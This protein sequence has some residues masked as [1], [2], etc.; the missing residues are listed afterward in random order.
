METVTATPPGANPPITET[1]S[2][3][4]AAAESGDLSTFL[5]SEEDARLGKP[6]EK[7]TR[8]KP[9]SETPKVEAKPSKWDAKPEKPAP[10][11][12]KPA[13]KGPSQA[14]KDA[15]ERIRTRVRE[16][17]DIATAEAR[18]RIK[19]LEQ[20]ITKVAA[21]K[22]AEPAPAPPTP[23]RLTKAEIAKYQALPDAPKL[24]DKDANGEFLYDT[25]AE[26][27]IA[28]SHF[29]G[30]HQATQYAQASRQREQVIARSRHEAERTKTFGDRV[31][32]WK[33]ENQALLVDAT[34]TKPDG[35][36][37]TVK[38]LPL[39][40]AGDYFR[41]LHGW[42]MLAHLNQQRRAS[43]QEPLPP[44]VDH[45]IAEHFYG[46]E[47]PAGLAI[48]LDQHPQ[49]LAW[50]R[51]ATSEGDLATR[52]GRIEERASGSHKAATTAPATGGTG[53]T[54]KPKTTDD[55]AREAEKAVARSVSSVKPPDTTLGKASETVD[56]KERALAEG[57]V[58]LFLELEQQE[59]IER[60]T[61]HRRKR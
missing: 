9:A 26:H 56:A 14:D 50:L 51:A 33:A 54:T 45:A 17:V 20:Q 10:V 58:G 28:L 25:A 8:E 4:R 15:D 44:T 53:T 23:G 59:R 24:D 21:P 61:G 34:V 2:A 42:A 30:Q 47:N 55:A 36:T 1:V 32:K 11:E 7:V 6:H 5:R 49:E 18:N 22:P 31:E 29:I 60:F 39:T 37:E 41:G 57:N 19:E 52:F 46:T 12:T 27:A 3:G 13:P 16:A 40:Q 35:T 43:G 48:Y 38:T